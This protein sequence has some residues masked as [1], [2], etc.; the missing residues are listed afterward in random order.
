[1]PIRPRPSKPALAAALLLAASLVLPPVFA[2]PAKVGS[3]AANSKTAKKSPP[4]K[5]TA[6]KG[7]PKPAK[8]G[9]SKTKRAATVVA[10][11]TTAAAVAATPPANIAEKQAD[12]G[13]LRSRIEALRK[14]L[15][16][17]ESTRADAADRLREA[18]RSIST[19]QRDLHQ[20]STQRGGLQ[21]NLLDLSQQSQTLEST[22]GEQQ[23]RLEQLV[24]RQYLQ[25]NPE[26]LQHFLNGG[27]PNQLARDLHY[28]GAIA[29]ARG[30]LLAEIRGSLRK[31]QAL[32]EATRE[33]AEELGA[34][35]TQQKERHAQLL[36]QREER[37]LLLQS[38]A[39]K[40]ATQRKEI[41]SL[42][43][44]EKR[45]SQL[46][47]RLSRIIA[48]KPK[49]VPAEKPARE[50]S[51]PKPA[52]LENRHLPE[53]S[54]GNFAKLKGSLRLPV[55]GNISGRFGAT[56]EGGGN[57]KGVFIRTAQGSDVRAVANG[58]V[59][60]AEW[61]RGF[62]N[63]LIID[64]GDAYLSIYG[65]NDALLKQVGDSVKGGETVA[66]VGNSGGN[67]ESGLYF[68]LR[69]Q[70]QALDPMKWASLK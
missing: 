47:D 5:K 35:E 28:L 40:I 25:G 10:A 61:M 30:E 55:R 32:A 3:A 57:W 64:H 58:R 45:L 68:E 13:E 39:G 20:L 60:F 16:S 31:K 18:E 43:Q 50:T 12:L 56:R 63:L 59:V 22:L 4:T 26:T 34:V 6:G 21:K 19:L 70:G 1:M 38:I 69:H 44:D 2:A 54:A 46:I 29:R 15:A 41:G 33:R 65:N 52:E 24:Y 53:A 17:N 14:E 36:A 23:A 42:Q 66:S 67:P 9:V 27:D 51:R 62:G 8:A 37:K 48:S 49:P 7:A 11:T